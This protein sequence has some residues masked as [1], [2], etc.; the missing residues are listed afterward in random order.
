MY[1][2]YAHVQFIIELLST[3][4]NKATDVL[5]DILMNVYYFYGMACI[6]A[7]QQSVYNVACAA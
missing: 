4:K 1:A 5:A 3:F 2:L 7:V 6:Y